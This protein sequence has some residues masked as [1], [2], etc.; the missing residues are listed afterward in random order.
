MV[1]EQQIKS[2]IEELDVE[3]DGDELSL[4]S[5]KLDAIRSRL[6]LP[7]DELSDAALER[8]L[9]GSAIVRS[10][11]AATAEEFEDLTQKRSETYSFTVDNSDLDALLKTGGRGRG[12]S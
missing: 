4:T 9:R 6:D 10:E 12:S 2:P 3:L 7:S 5:E 8:L 11:E 1:D